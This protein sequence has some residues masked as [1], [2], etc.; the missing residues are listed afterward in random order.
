MKLGEQSDSDTKGSELV[1]IHNSRRKLLVRFPIRNFIRFLLRRRHCGTSFPRKVPLRCLTARE[2]GKM[3][4]SAFLFLKI[5]ICSKG[6]AVSLLQTF[7]LKFKIKRVCSAPDVNLHYFHVKLK[8]IGR[9][10]LPLI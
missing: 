3:E 10:V 5:Q 6:F 9:H 8:V 1:T 2:R 4:R 7:C